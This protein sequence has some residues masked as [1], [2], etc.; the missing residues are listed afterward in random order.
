VN[1]LTEGETVVLYPS[2][3]LSE[4]TRVASRT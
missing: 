3:D 2:V 4:G 1:G